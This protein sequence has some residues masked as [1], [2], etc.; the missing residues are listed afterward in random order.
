M[1]TPDFMATFKICII[2]DKEKSDHTWNVKIRIIHNRHIFYIGTKDYITFKS[3]D[4]N[5]AILEDSSI[6]ARHLR[7]IASYRRILDDLGDVVDTYTVAQIANILKRNTQE[8]IDFFKF[9]DT[10]IKSIHKQ[11]RTKTAGSYQSTKNNLMG[12]T[13]MTVLPISFLTSKFMKDFDVWLRRHKGLDRK[14]KPAVLTMGDAGVNKNMSNIR[15][16]FNLAKLEFN[17]YDI[18]DIQIKNDPF[19]VYKL[20][21]VGV[22]EESR[23]LE[24]LDIKRIRD[25][26]L[27]LKRDI[28]GRD[29]FMISLYLMGMNC[30]DLYKCLP[31]PGGR[32]NYNRTKTKDRMK[33]KA[34]MSVLIEPELKPLLEKYKGEKYAF[35]FSKRYANP[36]SFVKNVDK[37]LKNI[38]KELNLEIPGNLTSYYARHSWA[39]IAANDCDIPTHVIG[40][41]LSHSSEDLKITERYIKKSYK[42]IDEANRKVLDLLNKTN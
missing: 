10:V 33:N 23:S 36:E 37:G 41:S 15:A 12:F 24:A 30:I 8:E 11:G 21:E 18:G 25:M 29:V 38:G 2:K 20:P 39:S 14:D 6:Y 35:D 22:P 27:T 16:T 40:K 32:I 7:T 4:K 9:M 17:N 26:E 5:K 19:V 13:G 3:L 28:L 42:V 34:V 31:P 1:F